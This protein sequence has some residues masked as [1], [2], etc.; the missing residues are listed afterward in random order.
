MRSSK[1][2]RTRLGVASHW[3]GSSMRPQVW[4]MLLTKPLRSKSQRQ[5]SPMAID[6]TAIHQIA[7]RAL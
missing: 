1:L 2:R 4:R 7:I 3:I 6:A 5:D